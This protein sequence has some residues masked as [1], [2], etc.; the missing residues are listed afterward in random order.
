MHPQLFEVV[1]VLL[2]SFGIVNGDKAAGLVSSTSLS[3]GDHET[4][5]MRILLVASRDRKI[6]TSQLEVRRTTSVGSTL[7]MVILVLF[8]LRIFYIW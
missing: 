4:L 1:V 2:G 3:P 8:I 6:D 5:S 7:F